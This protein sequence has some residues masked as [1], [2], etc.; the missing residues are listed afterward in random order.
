M[1]TLTF[2]GHTVFCTD[3]TASA[4]F[5]EDVLGFT[6]GTADEA[7]LSVLAPV[8][9]SPGVTVSVLLHQSDQP[10]PTDLGSFETADVDAVVGRVREAGGTVTTGPT[11]APWGVREAAVSDPDGNG[12]YISGPLQQADR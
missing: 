7:H 12:L 8:T 6:R 3:L 11:D 9:D 4:R 10:Q 1:T 5:Y 2:T